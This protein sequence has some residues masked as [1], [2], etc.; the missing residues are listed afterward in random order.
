VEL[1]ALPN[2][3]RVVLEPMPGLLSAA[4]G[5]FVRVGARWE[6]AEENGVAHL[7]EHMAFKGAGGRDARAFA[8]AAESVGAA[9]NASTGYERTS[10]YARVIREHAPF[11]LELIADI[12]LEPHWEPAELEKEK[13]VV[14][15]EMGEAFDQPD[16]RVFEVH[17]AA[18]FPG[19][20]LGRAILGAEETLAAISIETLRAFRDRHYTADRVVIVA[21]GGF[22]RAAILD[23]TERRFSGLAAGGDAALEPAQAAPAAV[24]EARR[25]EQA[26]VVL[27]WPGVA[28]GA[29]EIY[30][31]RLLSEILGGG[32]SSRLFQ[33]VREARGLAY[34]I[35]SYLEPYEDAGRLGVYAGCAPKDAA[36]VRALTIAALADLAEHGPTAK[37]LDRAKTVVCAQLLMAAEAPLNRAEARAGQVFTRG[38]L[39]AFE[40]LA[41]S[42][43]AVDVEGVRRLAAAALSGAHVQATVGPKSAVAARTRRRPGAATPA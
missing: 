12:V 41:Q 11:A 40:T 32:F 18:A 38:A 20:A 10:Y 42:L 15:Q 5:V 33:E 16:D 43:R 25:L 4:V 37:E 22:D 1:I 21:A 14:R 23:T 24:H 27:S 2:G 39:V 31:A 35:D 9:L 29:G 13:G 8:E 19:Q 34:A 36:E 28:T 26:H 3:V 17:Q 30:A 6:A 7:F